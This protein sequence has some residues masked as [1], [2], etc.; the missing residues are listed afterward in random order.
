MS[1][2]AITNMLRA[3]TVDEIANEEV[4]IVLGTPTATPSR[5]SLVPYRTDMRTAI[6][7]TFEQ[8]CEDAGNKDLVKHVA[9]KTRIIF[10]ASGD[11][12][13]TGPASMLETLKALSVDC[14][15]DDQTNIKITFKYIETATGVVNK[16][17][18]FW[19]DIREPPLAIPETEDVK[20]AAIMK[21][22]N[23]CGF[24]TT[25]DKIHFPKD[26]FGQSKGVVHVNFNWEF[27]GWYVREFQANFKSIILG[28]AGATKINFSKQFTDEQ[29]RVCNCC[30]SA[31]GCL[32]SR[33]G[34]K[35]KTTKRERDAAH[36]AYVE[37][38]K[39][40]KSASSASSSMD[41]A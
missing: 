3:L 24:T 23:T 39:K 9:E 4:S 29:L 28:K 10:M 36:A 19:A 1:V 30:L 22:F 31:D 35:D 14:P 21:L 8:A 27:S 26:D 11:L 16:T 2:I 40:R 32:N 13:V 20:R 18:C 5:P 41:A 12:T 38:M 6:F 33:K 7:L 17:D 25:P 34:G 15:T 37:R